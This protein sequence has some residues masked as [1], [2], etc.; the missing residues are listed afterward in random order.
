MAR[1]E[2]G[3]FNRGRIAEFGTV[4]RGCIDCPHN[5]PWDNDPDNE[6]RVCSAF[7]FRKGKIP[8]GK[9]IDYR[10]ESWCGLEIIKNPYDDA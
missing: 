10:A 5:R 6:Q 3:E 1:R 8:S 2:E 9:I 7:P 4:V